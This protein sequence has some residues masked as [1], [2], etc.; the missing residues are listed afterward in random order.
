MYKSKVLVGCVLL[1]YILFVIYEFRGDSDIAYNLDCLL[2]PLVAIIYLFF[3]KKRNIFFLLFILCYSISDL[4]GVVMAYVSNNGIADLNKMDYFIG[5]SLFILAYLFLFVKIIRSLSLFYVFKNF[6]IHLLVLTIL[7]VYLVYVLQVILGP[8]INMSNEYY[9]E[10]VYN[11]VMLLLLSVALLNYFYRDNKKSLYLFIGSLC[12]V[13]SE[14]MQVAY[15]YIAQRS[16]LNF[17]STTLTLVAF[18][19]F[20]QQSQLLNDLNQEEK[21]MVM[22]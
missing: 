4:L 14:V 6:K 9:L 22:E 19:F 2:T 7:N 20:Y 10:M 17:I 21:Y 12:I 8:N 15:F 18:Y 16:L 1:V 3:A 13:F 5:N 11:I